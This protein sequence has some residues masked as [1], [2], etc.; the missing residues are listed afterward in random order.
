MKSKE[1]FLSHIKRAHQ[2][3]EAWRKTRHHGER[4]PESLW[5]ALA[6][7]ARS[8]GISPVS[9]ALRLDYYALKRRVL[10]SEPVRQSRLKAVTP[11][12]ELPLLGPPASSPRCTVELAKNTGASMTI[13]WEGQAAVDVIGL[14][15]TF[16][17]AR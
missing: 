1:L 17:R 9:Q 10:E 12:V 7:L 5:N 13:R 4:I 11:F 2:Q 15:E 6:A 14:A 8:H 3:L 16:W